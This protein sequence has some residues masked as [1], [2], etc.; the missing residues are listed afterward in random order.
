M[1]ETTKS[2]S[3]LEIIQGSDYEIVIT[4]DDTHQWNDKKYRVTIVKDF[5]HTAFNGDIS[6]SGKLA[7]GDASVSSGGTISNSTD[8]GVGNI[9]IGGTTLDGSTRTGGT[10]TIKLDQAKT[11]ALD[12]DFDGFWDLLEGSPV[13]SPT[14]FIRQAQGEVYVNPMATAPTDFE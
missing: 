3:N 14:E 4:M 1:P 11:A 12:D 13:S 8:S 2:Y 5:A 9:T 7:F 6:S 10:I